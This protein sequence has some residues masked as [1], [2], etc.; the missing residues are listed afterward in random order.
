MS[1][2]KKIGL[3]FLLAI[4]EIL[5]VLF[6]LSTLYYYDK[7]SSTLFRSLKIFF[8]LGILLINS[9]RLGKES[10]KKGYLV[11]LKFGSF[12]VILSFL[13]TLFLKSFQLKNILYYFLILSSSILGSMIGISQKKKDVE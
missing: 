11:G 2:C 3:R 4:I 6:L 8:F 10:L 7:I 12:F 1:Y 9:Y 13:L 5:L